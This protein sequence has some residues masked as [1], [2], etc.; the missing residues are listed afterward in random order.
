MKSKTCLSVA[1]VLISIMIF[2]CKGSD[3]DTVEPVLETSSAGTE[4]LELTPGLTI[5]VELGDTNYVFGQIV[6]A[7]LN[8]NGDVLILDTSTMNIRKYSSVGDFIGAAG[9][10]GTGPGEFQMPRGMAVLGNDDFIITDMAGG[11]V[12]VF[13]DSL[14]WKSNITGFFPRPPLTVRTAGDSAFVGMLPVFDREEGLNGYSI[15]RMQNSPEPVTVYNEEMR[16]F[17]PS[18]I[19]PLGAEKDPI[20]TSDNSGHVFIAEPGAD[21]IK[22]T[23]YS[24]DGEPFLTIDE[25]AEKEEKTQEELAQEQAEFEEFSVRRGS[26]GGRMSG[27][28]IS[29][30]PILY[31]RAVT[32]LGIDNEERLWVRLGA[33]RYPFWNI[34]DFEGELLFTASMETDDPD[35]DYMVVRITENGATA[36]I[37]D[38]ITWPRVLVLEIPDTE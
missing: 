19:G 27:M 17:D 35:M 32:D 33:Y 21:A 25:N 34:Y 15:I 14:N 7:L 26:H 11:A 23:G 18:R 31:R 6:E 2:S 38:P 24:Q 3:N 29:F 16:T 9:R 22:I 4:H 28:E 37:P 10:Q 36:W 20:F 8:E 30:D 1:T 5:G 12:C 13:D